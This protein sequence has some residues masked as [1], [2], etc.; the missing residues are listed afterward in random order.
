MKGVRGL[1]YG[2][3][4]QLARDSPANAIYMS[5]Y[6][7]S[8]YQGSQM[9]PLVPNWFVNFMCG[10]TAGVLS[11]L[12]I[13]P[14]DVVKNRIQADTRQ[15]YYTGFWDCALKAYRDEGWKAFYRGSMAVSVRAFPVNAVC[16]AVYTELLVYLNGP[17]QPVEKKPDFHVH[18]KLD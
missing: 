7:L 16:L 10:G 8:S 2:F 5:F 14:I 17:S 9:F 15:K 18:S 1:F 12:A 13:M 11:W 3:W 4:A 6:K